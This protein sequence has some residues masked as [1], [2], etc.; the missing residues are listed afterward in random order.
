MSKIQSPKS[1][2]RETEPSNANAQGDPADVGHTLD[3]GQRPADVERLRLDLGLRVTDLRKSFLTPAGERIEVLR[4]VSFSAG[5]GEAISIMGASGA[6]KSTL[7]QLICGLEAADHGS[8]L[9]GQFAIDRATSSALARFR[10]Q[11]V[12]FVFQFHHLLPD[13]TATEN[14]SLPLLITRTHRSQAIQLAAEMLA[15]VGLDSRMAASVVGHLSGGEQQRVAV[16]RALITRPS[17]VLADEPSGNLDTATGDEIARSLISYAHDNG[18]L[19]IIA[20]HNRAV[21]QVT[22]RTLF[23]RDGKL[24]EA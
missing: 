5:P 20:T 16:C 8:I 17:L 21:A 24:C 3:V 11:Q 10:N 19:V 2:T 23:L 9:A 13:L 12:G 22:D 6:G 7:L 18:A 15:K 1:E 14:V 4:G